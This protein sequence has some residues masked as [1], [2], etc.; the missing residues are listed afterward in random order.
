MKVGNWWTN[1]TA[2]IAAKQPVTY[3]F[4]NGRYAYIQSRVLATDVLNPT[5]NINVV[6]VLDISNPPLP[7][8]VAAYTAPASGVEWDVNHME[9]AN[10]Y[11]YLGHV[12]LQIA[13]GQG[14]DFN[15]VWE[16][17]YT[18]CPAYNNYNPANRGSFIVANITN[19]ATLTGMFNVPLSVTTYA[20][21][22]AFY[23]PTNL[24]NYW[25]YIADGW[26]DIVDMGDPASGLLHTYV[27][28]TF[29]P[30][31][32]TVDP[33]LNGWPT[34]MDKVWRVHGFDQIMTS[35]WQ[36]YWYAYFVTGALPGGVL[37][38]D[39]WDVA[40]PLAPFRLVPWG[41]NASLAY[42]YG[43][44][45]GQFSDDT[46]VASGIFGGDM[47]YF[48][49]KADYTPPSFTT[50][51]FANTGWWH[52]YCGTTQCGI[53]NA[54]TLLQVQV[55]DNV[56]VTRV[57]MRAYFYDTANIWWN[58]CY[59][60]YPGSG[61]RGYIALGN[62]AGPDANNFW[63]LTVD[64]SQ[65]WWTGWVRFRAVANDAGGN[66][67]YAYNMG[68][69]WFVTATPAISVEV[70][71]AGTD[72]AYVWSTT[73]VAAQVTPVAGDVHIVR[74]LFKVDGLSIGDG[75]YNPSTDRWYVNWNT[76]LVGDG[77]HVITAEVT[78]SNSA[79]AASDPVTKYVAN[80]GPD[81]MITAPLAGQMVYGSTTCG[82]HLMDAQY[83]VPIHSR[84]LRARPSCRR[85][86]GRHRDRLRH[87]SG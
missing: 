1:P 25:A 42:A 57:R 60:G 8:E 82:A 5:A 19:P 38:L 4:I 43:N 86:L 3:V 32:A 39:H 30:Y 51:G 12:Y 13:N 40:L 74:V 6:R 29:N 73:T 79:T 62:A 85:H 36:P 11:T 80:G 26:C 68:G 55:V 7:A 27:R 87:G 71:P 58:Y 70:G 17:A 64:P 10:A 44:Y 54:P 83:P 33:N 61:S 48:L 84:R 22:S 31:N 28:A 35:Y 66:L 16:P 47:L 24:G 45:F 77:N 63:T 46:W 37:S 69:D 81:S 72:Y 53:L 78:T 14:L 15:G 49:N 67:T 76:T 34:M 59:P 18:N 75:L 50:S 65:F 41:T 9:L 20:Y 52:P 23:V 21:M 56:A 2:A